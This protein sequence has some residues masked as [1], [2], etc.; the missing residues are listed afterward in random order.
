MELIYRENKYPDSTVRKN[1]AV[2]YKRD[3]LS[4]N[5]WFNHRRK[6]DKQQ[7][8]FDLNIELQ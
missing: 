8:N 3:E 6:K 4:I 2:D 1:L 5:N 7:H